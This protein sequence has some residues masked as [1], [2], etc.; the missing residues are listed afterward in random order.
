MYRNNRDQPWYTWGTMRF[1]T[2]LGIGAVLGGI[3]IY[4]VLQHQSRS[5][6]SP[7]I[8]SIARPLDAYAIEELAA[9]T[10]APSPVQLDTVTA[11][12]AAYTVQQFSYAVDDVRSG[13]PDA[14]YRV[15]GVAHIPADPPP[16]GGYPVIV[17]FRGYA[18]RETYYPGQGTEHS[19]QVLASHGFLSLA[20]DF[21]G[22]GSSSNPSKDIFE[23]RFQTYTTALTMLASVSTIPFA[24]AS[25]I[26]VWGHSNGGQI[27]LTAL[28]A[29]GKPYPVS[30]WAPV[31]KPFPYSI[32]YYTDE[33]DDQGKFLRQKLAAFES[34]YDAKQYALTEYVSRLA[35]PVILHQG[36]ADD[37]VPQKWSDEFVALLRGQNKEIEYF[38]YPGTDHNLTPG[39][40]TVITRDINFFTENL[41]E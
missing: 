18:N 27:A 4:G 33:A 24:D 38:T 3:V 26:G 5:V 23:E 30:L 22:Y 25:R 28:E 20:P 32:L 2:G 11:T 10:F 7:I 19:A 36:G 1:L 39:W 31:T 21:L 12:T 8:R 14:R 6:V 29:S 16:P 17:Q 13:I 35:G 34:V 9:V 41:K 40:D 37:A 15:S